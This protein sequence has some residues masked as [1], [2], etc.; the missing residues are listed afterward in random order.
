MQGPGH[1]LHRAKRAARLRALTVPGR[2]AAHGLGLLRRKNTQPLGCSGRFFGY[3]A[4][5]VESGAH[6][7]CRAGASGYACQVNS[8]EVSVALATPGSPLPEVIPGPSRA[9]LARGARKPKTPGPRKCDFNMRTFYE[10]SPFCFLGRGGVH[11][12]D[13]GIRKP[14]IEPRSGCPSRHPDPYVDVPASTSMRME[15]SALHMPGSQ[16]KGYY[17]TVPCRQ[18]CTPE[19][20]RQVRCPCFRSKSHWLSQFFTW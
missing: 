3:L 5:Q 10:V 18:Q 15:K 19:V 13:L 14:S 11:G 6:R 1:S 4:F 2:P 8:I 7:R 16:D 9:P 12:W 20:C 17:A